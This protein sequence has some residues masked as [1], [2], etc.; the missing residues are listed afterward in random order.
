MRVAK[1]EIRHW[2]EFDNVVINEDLGVATE[3][4]R[5]ILHG[6]G[7]GTKRLTGLPAFVAGLG[8]EV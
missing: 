8:D 4:V 1:D 2:V 3:A 6:A 5:A 7:S